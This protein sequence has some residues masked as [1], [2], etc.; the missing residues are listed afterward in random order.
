MKWNKDRSLKILAILGWCS[1]AILFFMGA[2]AAVESK[3]HHG[4]K[5]VE[6]HLIH[7]ED[8]NDLIT[9]E[10]IKDK[11]LKTYNLDLVGVEVDLLDLEGLENVLR[12]E[13]FIVNADAYI[14]AKEVL[15]IDIAQR[16]PILRVMGLDGSNFYLDNNGFKLPLS[17]HFTARVP[18]VS[19]GVSEYKNDFLENKNSLRSA[20]HLVKKAREDE[21]LNAWM[22]GIY[23]HRDGDLWL[24]GNVGDFKVIFGDE[25][26]LDRKIGKLKT[27]FSTGLKITG[28]RNI[29]TIDLRYEKQVITK[30]PSKV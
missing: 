4:I 5:N 14:D 17:R 13:P 6:Y 12:A 1:V 24:S 2:S 20:Y 11:I 26:N 27:F 8:G 23:V 16:A 15:H 9:V 10:E 29:E 7:L 22:E 3:A 18:I 28:W 21:F 25:N 30:A 19:G